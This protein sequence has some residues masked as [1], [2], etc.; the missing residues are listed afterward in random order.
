MMRA[1]TEPMPTT[2]GAI[3]GIH[4]VKIPVTD[5][6]RSRAW[7]EPLFELVPLTEFRDDH[8]GVVRGVSYHSL[9]N[10]ALALRE[11]PDAARGLAG[12]DCFAMMLRGRPDVEHWCGRLDAFGIAHSDII[13]VPIGSILTFADP[14]GIELRFYSL[15]PTGASA[16]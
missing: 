7:Y 1:V 6:V 4:H 2:L 16:S 14:D 10:L 15:D 9:G 11:H 12:Y 8:D 5:L 3:L 13:D